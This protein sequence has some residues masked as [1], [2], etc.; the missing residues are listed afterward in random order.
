[1]HSQFSK[2]DF[3]FLV[4][5]FSLWHEMKLAEHG[6]L[7]KWVNY[8]STDFTCLLAIKLQVCRLLSNSL[9]IL[10]LE[11]ALCSGDA[12]SSCNMP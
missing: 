9:F 3:F 1:M 10:K 5:S 6:S 8:C 11:T 12:L 4:S 2:M 7:W